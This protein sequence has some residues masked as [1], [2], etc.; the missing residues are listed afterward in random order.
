ME[1]NYKQ[2]IIRSDAAGVSLSNEWKPIAQIN[3][4][5]DD[6][7]FFKFWMESNFTR[8]YTS[9]KDAEMEGYLFA[10]NWIDNNKA[11]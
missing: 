3:W 8:S 6:K 11:G 9:Y 10:R 1:E 2:Y 4:I 7:Q 5:Q